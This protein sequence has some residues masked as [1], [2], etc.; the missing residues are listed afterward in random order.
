LARYR[1]G[2]YRLTLCGDAATGAKEAQVARRVVD[3]G[4]V[5][6]LENLAPTGK[7]DGRWIV[8]NEAVYRHLEIPIKDRCGAAPRKVR[9]AMMALGWVVVKGSVPGRRREAAHL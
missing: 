9:E 8:T 6:R 4:Y 5:E 7:R 2:G 1:S 3:D